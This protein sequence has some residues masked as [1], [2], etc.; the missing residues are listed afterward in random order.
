MA[1]TL[2]NEQYLTLLNFTS[3]IYE[4]EVECKLQEKAFG[5]KCNKPKYMGQDLTTFRRVYAM[6]A[7]QK[8]KAAFG[9]DKERIIFLL[10]LLIPNNMSFAKSFTKACELHFKICD[11]RKINDLYSKR[12]NSFVAKT[13]DKILNQL[14]ITFYVTPEHARLKIV[15]ILQFATVYY[16]MDND[17]DKEPTKVL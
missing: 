4:R 6:D 7:Y 12:E 14:A 10:N 2:T 8:H 11:V 15:E 1:K 3:Q 13:W 16:Q 9:S 17:D 5:I